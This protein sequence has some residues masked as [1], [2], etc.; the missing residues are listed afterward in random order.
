M[1]R[2]NRDPLLLGIV[3][4]YHLL[5]PAV[6]A[7]VE[8]AIKLLETD[9]FPKQYRCK[10]AGADQHSI[11]IS[12]GGETVWVIYKVLVLSKVIDLMQIRLDGPLNKAAQRLIEMW[13]FFPKG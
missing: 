4:A 2:I 11:R 9:T 5:D 3:P 12:S 10:R 6:K 13:E 7:D 8:K 1:Y